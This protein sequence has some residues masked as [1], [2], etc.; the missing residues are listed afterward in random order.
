MTPRGHGNLRR[1]P[2][3]SFRLAPSSAYQPTEA[4]PSTPVTRAEPIRMCRK[5]P[6]AT[7]GR[8][9]RPATRRRVSYPVSDSMSCIRRAMRYCLCA[10]CSAWP[11]HLSRVRRVVCTRTRRGGRGAAASTKA[12]PTTEWSDGFSDPRSAF[13]NR[14]RR[15]DGRGALHHDPPHHD[16]QD[17]Q[18]HGASHE[19][20]AD[21]L[22][23]EQ[24]AQHRAEGD[25]NE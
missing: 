2:T 20:G 10:H 1:R 25:P 3:T 16:G 6:F 4:R 14:R 13:F 9:R 17:H 11:A 7:G 24:P 18:R 23:A 22:R 15:L 21:A 12:R 8:G 5:R 19:D